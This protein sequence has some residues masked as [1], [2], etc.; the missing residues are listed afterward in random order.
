MMEF[1]RPE[2]RATFWRW[3]EALGGGAVICVGAYWA[4][5]PGGL[6]GVIGAI[7]MLVGT[8]VLAM[9]IQRGRFRAERG[10]GP[11]TVDV[12]E[13]QV[14]YFGPLTGGALALRDLEELALIRSRQ[15]PHWRLSTKDEDLFIPV[16]ADGSDALFDAFTVLPG[17]KMQRMLSALQDQSAQDIVIWTRGPVR[18]PTLSLH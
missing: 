2:L 13:G 11:G 5:G 10:D 16:N 6:I 3:R 4:F 1:V 8:I 12:D 14:M 18:P 15:T 9:G 7:V 17:L